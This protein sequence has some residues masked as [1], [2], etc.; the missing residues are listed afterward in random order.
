M[1]LTAGSGDHAWEHASACD[2]HVCV[3]FKWTNLEECVKLQS[4]GSE[5]EIKK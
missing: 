4:G 2:F 5:E 3:V 1:I